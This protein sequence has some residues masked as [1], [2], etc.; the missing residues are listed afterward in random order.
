MNKLVRSVGNV[1]SAAKS[2]F[3]EIWDLIS[4]EVIHW[5]MAE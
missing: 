4:F 2:R 3:A 1:I 5:I